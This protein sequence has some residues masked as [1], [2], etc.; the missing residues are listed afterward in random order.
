M[1]T[2]RAL[3][4]FGIVA[5]FPS[6][7][8]SEGDKISGMQLGPCWDS[9]TKPANDVDVSHMTERLIRTSSK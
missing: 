8:E 5:H 4:A 3:A 1:L 6:D 9:F 7:G 2:D